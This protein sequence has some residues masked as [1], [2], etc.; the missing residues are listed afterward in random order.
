MSVIKAEI[1]TLSN[2]G[3]APCILFEKLLKDFEKK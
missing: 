3:I 2:N 1:Q